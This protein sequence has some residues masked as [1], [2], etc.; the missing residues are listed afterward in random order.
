[1]DG[2]REQ[3]WLG[4]LDRRRVKNDELN[5]QLISTDQASPNLLNNIN[6]TVD[7]FK[8]LEYECMHKTFE[9][10]EEKIT[11]LAA[12]NTLSG[13]TK[14]CVV[15][16]YYKDKTMT[17]IAKDLNLC[18]S[19]VSQLTTIGINILKKRIPKKTYKK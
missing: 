9:L 13:K 6:I 2:L 18:E 15:D 8:P 1:L 17:E 3:D 7:H 10:E 11:I 16:Y 19:R 12:V 5:F 4:K 14:H